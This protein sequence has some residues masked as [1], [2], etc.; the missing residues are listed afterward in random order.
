MRKA[1]FL[2]RLL[3]VVVYALIGLLPIFILPFTSFVGSSKVVLVSVGVFLALLLLVV[4]NLRDG[5][6]V[7]PR[8]WLFL[9]Y[10]SVV[11]MYLASAIASPHRARFR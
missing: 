1:S 8:T 5:T 4:Q 10:L 9:S 6:I 11:L 2:D 3:V 7:F